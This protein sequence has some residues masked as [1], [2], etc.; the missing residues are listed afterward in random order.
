MY[1]P[2]LDQT[3]LDKGIKLLTEGPII[4]RLSVRIWVASEG[5]NMIPEGRP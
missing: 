5:I 4:P 3:W 2:I 1:I